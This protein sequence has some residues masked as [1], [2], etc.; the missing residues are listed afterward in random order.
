MIRPFVQKDLYDRIFLHQ[1]NMDYEEFFKKFVP[2]SHM[3]ADYGGV[4]ASVEE[5]HDKNRDVLIEMRD[6]F[7]FEENQMNFKYEHLAEKPE[8][9]DDGE[10]VDA[11]DE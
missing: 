1:T 7:L 5:L 11:K 8:N 10:F 3:P 6:Y 9:D 2:K 4:L